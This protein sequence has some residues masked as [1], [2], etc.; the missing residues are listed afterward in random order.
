MLFSIWFFV[1]YFVFVWVFLSRVLLDPVLSVYTRSR[2]GVV[3]L[4][5]VFAALFPDVAQDVV[6]IPTVLPSRKEGMSLQIHQCK[7]NRGLRGLVGSLKTIGEGRLVS[8]F[9]RSVLKF[10]S[11]V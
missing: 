5:A 1:F 9:G 3:R 6:V 10:E 7:R 8:L 11:M 4:V 2:F